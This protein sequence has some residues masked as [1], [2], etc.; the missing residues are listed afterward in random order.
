LGKQC[1]SL[2]SLLFHSPLTHTL[3]GQIERMNV[4]TSLFSCCMSCIT[5][6]STILTF[7]CCETVW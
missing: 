4:A 3:Q 1:R 7:I 5:W 6:E 2:S